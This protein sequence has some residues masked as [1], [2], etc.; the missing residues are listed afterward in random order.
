MFPH[1]KA[2]K[3]K[4]IFKGIWVSNLQ[5]LIRFTN[6]VIMLIQCDTTVS[7]LNNIL[8]FILNILTLIIHQILSQLFSNP[9]G[10]DFIMKCDY[11]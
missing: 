4:K 5:F 8:K 9:T 2:F 1:Q 7:S 11:Y 3:I 6:S 10:P